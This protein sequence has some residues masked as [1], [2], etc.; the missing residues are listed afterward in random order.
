MNLLV[1][2]H[3]NPYFLCKTNGFCGMQFAFLAELCVALGFQ[4]FKVLQ[5]HIPS[6]L[7]ANELW[8]G[9]SSSSSWWARTKSYINSSSVT[10]MV[11]FIL[12]LG[13][14]HLDNLLI[15]RVSAEVVH[16]DYD[17]CFEKGT[18][19]RIPEVVPFRMT[20][21]MQ[22]RVYSKIAAVA[23]SQQFRC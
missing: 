3:K 22:V 12:G 7:L 10:S 19:S 9:S 15:D 23:A 21:T 11:G 8:C 17:V 6:K 1:E 20:R 14:R 18:N 13:D 16:I 2:V 5:D 4:V